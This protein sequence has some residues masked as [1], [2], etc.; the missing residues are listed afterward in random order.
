MSFDLARAAAHVHGHVGWLAAATLVH[1]A[2]L[3]RRRGRKAHLSVAVAALLPTLAG[4]LGVWIYGPY[5]DRIK[6]GIFLEAP[7]VGLLFERKEHLAFGAILLSWAG[8]AAYAL[9]LRTDGPARDSLRTLAH[10][11]FV[12]AAALAVVVAVLGTIVASFRS[13]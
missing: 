1:P 9:A 7:W 12:A 2:I 8:A 6:Q 11:A 10:R 5:R 3:L 13:L 4:G